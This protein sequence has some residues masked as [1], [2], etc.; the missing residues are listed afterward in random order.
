MAVDER[1][2][3]SVREG[4]GPILRF[5]RWS[6]ACLSF[7]RNQP[8]AGGSLDPDRLARLGVDVVRRPTGGRTVLH[9]DEL[10]YAVVA[11]DR[12]FGTPRAA[13]RRINSI[14]LEG[15]AR[16]GAPVSLQG[17]LAGRSPIPSTVPCFA[18]PVEGEVLAVGRKLIGSA[19]LC[20]DGVLLQHGSLP[21]RASSAHI[22]AAAVLG[23]DPGHPAFLATVLDPLPAWATIVEALTSAWE[24]SLGPVSRADP[25]APEFQPEAAAIAGHRD[26]SWIWRL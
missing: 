19:Q 26:S 22:E 6:P 5:Y 1:L 10:T 24:R 15:L 17:A 2:M 20:R 16:L 9:G 11:P 7:G 3:E 12:I 4:S 23:L 25:R 13:Y 14:L 8:T 21:L 18:E